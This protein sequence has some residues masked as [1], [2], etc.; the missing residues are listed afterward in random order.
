M[1]EII[2]RKDTSNDK[3]NFGLYEAVES[4]FYVPYP[5]ISRNLTYIVIELFTNRAITRT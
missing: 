4:L 5:K 3:D 2:T 1:Y